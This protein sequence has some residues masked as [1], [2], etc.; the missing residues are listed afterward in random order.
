MS[1]QWLNPLTSTEINDVTMQPATSPL[2]G[3][4]LLSRSLFPQ[5]PFANADDLLFCQALSQ[6]LLRHSEARQFPD[7]IALGFWL[8]SAQLTSMLQPY[9]TF[10]AAQQIQLQPTG[11]WFH[12]AP[13]NVDSLF[14]Y[15]AILSLLCGNQ[16]IIRLSSAR[17]GSSALVLTALQ[18][19]AADYPSQCA[20]LQLITCPHHDAELTA[21]LAQV[22]GRVLW[23][24]DDAILAQRQLPMPAHARELCFHHKLSLCVLNASYVIQQFSRAE[25]SAN[26]QQMLALFVRDHLTFAQQACS[27]AKVLVWQGSDL[28]CV[29][30]QQLFW[31]ALTAYVAEHPVASLQGTEH[32]QALAAAQYFA[33]QGFAQGDVVEPYQPSITQ[34][35]RMSPEHATS[36]NPALQWTAPFAR[37][38]VPHLHEAI[39]L[40]HP[41]CG[42][43]I[44]LTV[45]TL[46]ELLP[47]LAQAH[48]TI[49]YV[50][51]TPEQCAAWLG[52]C[53]RG[54]ERMVPLG[55]SLQFGPIWDGIDLVLQFSRL[56]VIR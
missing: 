5:P 51:F 4:P 7:V 42:L 45:A 20:R 50:G 21:L 49:S 23:G 32:F 44:E 56:R 26:A 41:G 48:Q 1:L 12:S 37:L 52:Q 19:L 14:M 15:A 27:S 55:Q 28:E 8:R 39:T 10:Y 3:S 25:T 47:Q 11:L 43:F 31:P 2:A 13:R 9:Q 36:T 40:E 38:Q 34:P 54:V 18:Q 35:D 24:S 29:T 22:D 17:G 46:D 16:N 33:M 53:P 30:A 6:Q